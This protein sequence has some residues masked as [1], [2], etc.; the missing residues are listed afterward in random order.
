MT[1]ADMYF[2]ATVVGAIIFGVVG[3]AF[4]DSIDR[5]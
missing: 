4:F 3:V 5:K 1:L 2:V